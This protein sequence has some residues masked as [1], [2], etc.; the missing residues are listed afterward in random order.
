MSDEPLLLNSLVHLWKESTSLGALSWGCGCL[1]KNATSNINDVTCIP[2][3][4]VAMKFGKE[5]ADRLQ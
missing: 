3:L 2:C 1:I 5:C 4:W